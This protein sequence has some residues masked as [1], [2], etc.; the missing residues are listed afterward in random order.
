ME[1]LK[2]ILRDIK[3]DIYSPL[4]VIYKNNKEMNR[5]DYVNEEIAKRN[6]SLFIKDVDIKNKKIKITY[7]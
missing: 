4:K 1:T 5:I 2:E 3:C 6:I 7:K